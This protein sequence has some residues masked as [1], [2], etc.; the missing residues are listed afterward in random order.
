MKDVIISGFKHSKDYFGLYF[1]IK[2]L[3]QFNFLQS[4]RDKKIIQ[5]FTEFNYE[6]YLKVNSS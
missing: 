1:N 2:S 4:C 5:K 3:Q 6:L